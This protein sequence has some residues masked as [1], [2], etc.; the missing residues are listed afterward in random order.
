MVC[1]ATSQLG[2][3]VRLE[4]A[5]A[6]IDADDAERQR[7]VRRRERERDRRAPA[8]PDDHQRFG[9]AQ[10][11]QQPLEIAGD[12]VEVVAAVRAVAHAVTGQVDRDHPVG[13]HQ[14]VG[15]QVPPSRIARQAVER[16][17]GGLAA[18]VVAHRKRQTRRVDAVFGDGVRHVTR[19]LWPLWPSRRPSR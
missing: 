5:G 3:E 17:D 1:S 2:S 13:G 19:G 10:P 8:V 4:V 9:M 16:E 12:G 15:D 11:R 7:R 18:G 14:A 6:A